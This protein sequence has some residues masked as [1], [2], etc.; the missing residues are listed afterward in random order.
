MAALASQ[1]GLGAG[2]ERIV[3]VLPVQHESGQRISLF[4]VLTMKTLPLAWRSYVALVVGSSAAVVAAVL[5][6]NYVLDP[7]LI[8][9][10][11][12]PRM[13]QL[14][15]QREKLS[16][17]GKTYALARLRPQVVY[18][19]NSRTE[20]GLP[21]DFPAFAKQQVFNAAL[22]GASL[23][24]AM[25]MARHAAY[26]GPVQTAVWGIDAP[27]FHLAV[28]NTDFNRELVA[29]ARWYGLRRTL[30]DLK[31]ALSVDMTLDSLRILRGTYGSVC[32]SSLVFRGQRDD[33]CI[34]DR[35]HGW[36]G[37]Q[38]A[39]APRLDEFVRG[40]GPEADALAA[41]D[42]SVQ[43][44]CNVRTRVR[45]YINPTHA[46]MLD[47]LYWSGKW[48]A[49]EQW[50]VA[51]TNWA[52]KMRGRQ[53]DVRLFDFSGFN[54]VT[55]EAIPKASGQRGMQY[56]WET[57]HYRANVGRMILA[58]LFASGD[59]PADFGVELLPQQM[60]Q[61]L[62]ALRAGREAFHQDHPIET[63]MARQAAAGARQP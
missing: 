12:T 18:L 31:R 7:Y 24:D 45:L 27:S 60:A 14:R 15:P 2:P 49:M 29:D 36:G 26:M 44:L 40:D 6:L 8:H 52:A 17:W 19:G 16:A 43:Q 58:R 53:C 55:T 46:M 9:Q 63:A 22:S 32:Q 1:S 11:Q 47:A 39:I 33:A 30:L 51:L 57:S 61:H 34:N 42:H 25:G 4:P 50:Q 38:A 3:V 13:Y 59:V 54:S 5:G 37:T 28:G 48:R 23:S 10:W 21:A 62:A 20:L 41:L 35:I 56:Y